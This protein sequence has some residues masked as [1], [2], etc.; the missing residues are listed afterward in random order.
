MFSSSYN[1]YACLACQKP[2]RDLKITKIERFLLSVDSNAEKNDLYNLIVVEI[3]N[4]FI[5]YG[6]LF[7]FFL[8]ICKGE[9]NYC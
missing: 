1:E 5:N 8:E 3:F 7:V 9:T 4:I 2:K 6:I